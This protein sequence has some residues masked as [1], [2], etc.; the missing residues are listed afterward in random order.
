MTTGLKLHNLIAWKLADDFKF[1]NIIVNQKL[2]DKTTTKKYRL[3]KGQ[4]KSEWINEIS[5]VQ[6]A[7]QS[8]AGVWE[9]CSLPLVPCSNPFAIY[10]KESLLPSTKITVLW[11]VE[12][13]S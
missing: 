12:F 13:V 2:G 3:I 9:W 1:P 7:K 4:I 10:V 5:L 8:R 6:T 11:V